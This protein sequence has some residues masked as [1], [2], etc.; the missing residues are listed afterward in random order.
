ML[1]SWTLQAGTADKKDTMGSNEKD[2][3]GSNESAICC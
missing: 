3:M 1:T 2:T